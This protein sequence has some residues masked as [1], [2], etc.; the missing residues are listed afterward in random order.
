MQLLTVPETHFVCPNDPER[1]GFKYI[2]L[3]QTPT[4]ADAHIFFN[5][6]FA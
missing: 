6:A 3:D 5:I 4:R 1:A 2:T